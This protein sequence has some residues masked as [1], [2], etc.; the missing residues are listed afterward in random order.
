MVLK[1]EGKNPGKGEKLMKMMKKVLAMSTAAAMVF[2]MSVTVFAA[3]ATTGTATVKGVSEE[4]A[5]VTAYQLVSYDADKQV[6]VVDED[7]RDIYTV[8]SSDAAVVSEIAANHLDDLADFQLNINAEGNYVKELEG[9]TYLIIVTDTGATIYNPMLVSLEVKYPDGVVDG[10]VDADSKYMVDNVEVYAKSTTDVPV[11]K[12]ITDEEGNKIGK[13]GKYDDVYTG[14]TVYFTITGTI[15]SY[16]EQYD[17]DS[18]TYTL[19]DTVSTGLDLPEDLQT[20]LQ[21]QVSDAA[22][23]RVDGRTITIDY[24]NEYIMAHGG[25][26][27][28]IKYSATVNG[29]SVNFDPATNT[30]KVTY[31]NT[32]ST[33]TDG[34]E[35]TTR[36]YTFDLENAMVKVDSENQETKLTGA[37]FTLTSKTDPEKVFTGKTDADGNIEFKGLDAGE[38][39]LKETKAPEGYQLSGKEYTVIIEATYGEEDILESYTVTIKDGEQE[40][41]NMAYTKDDSDGAGTPANIVNTTLSSLPSTGGI[42]TTIFT[43]GGCAI[44]I[45]AAS[46]FFVS[47]RK[48]ESK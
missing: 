13:N 44:M 2:G 7:I 6:Y 30:V 41:G 16:S 33:S 25:E 8:G 43:I 17:N 27:V 3:P 20:T 32:P 42:G 14:T 34:E 38:Y 9:G 36:H 19:T 22:V 24:T 29:T 28:E 40:I 11:D 15:P 12:I 1:N 21:D 46:L 23:V 39:T 37:E 47:R 4:G 18:L 26:Q 45:A 5:V 48:S 10:E 35:V 31:S